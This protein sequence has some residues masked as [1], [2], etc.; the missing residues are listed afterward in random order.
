MTLAVTAFSEAAK[1][2]LEALEESADLTELEDVETWIER[3]NEDIR[4]HL[5][6]DLCTS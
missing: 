6:Y 5:E 3:L 2:A 4:Y 1:Q